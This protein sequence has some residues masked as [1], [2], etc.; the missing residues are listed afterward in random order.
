MTYTIRILYGAACAWLRQVE[1]LVQF[2][3]S[4]TAR[5]ISTESGKVETVIL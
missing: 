2:F 1:H 3:G 5:I 4:S